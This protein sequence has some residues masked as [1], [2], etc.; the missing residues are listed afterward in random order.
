MEIKK[1]IQLLEKY[2]IKPGL[3]RI[4]AI[5]SYMGHP[6]KDYG[7][8]IVGGTNGKGSTCAMIESIL[9]AAGHKTGLYTSPHLMMMNERIRVNF[10]AIGDEDIES[11][12]GQLFNI[13]DQH[14]GLSDTTY[15]EFLTAVALKYFS[16]QRIDMAVLEVG[17]GGRFDATNATEPDIS[18]I[19]NIAMDHQRYLGTTLEEIA[20]EKAGIIRTGK[21]FVTT[22]KTIV[23]RDILETTS[24]N[25]G[26][27]LYA[28]D[29][30]FF[31][32]ENESGMEFRSI[33]RTVHNV[34]LSLTGTHQMSNAS[35]AIQTVIL[36]ER[37]GTG[38][39]DEEIK[40]GLINTVWQGR[41]EKIRE[42]PVVIM[43]VAHNPAGIKT[44]IETVKRFY[45][46]KS[47]TVL[48]GVSR[49]K[50][51]RQMLD[52]LSEV[53]DYYIFTAYHGE[54]SLAPVE[55]NNHVK[56]IESAIVISSYKAYDAAVRYTP[57]D[58]LVIVTGS[59]YLIGEIKHYLEDIKLTNSKDGTYEL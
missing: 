30:D 22:D 33:L 50:E 16:E 45:N 11:I 39:S 29:K 14:S 21:P 53:A 1:R 25:K 38:I 58:G 17:M 56:G 57:D 32:D 43:D 40:R 49:D 10:N 2:G 51:W 42:K 37:L 15:F 55:L 48:F 26:G 19:T 4:S 59:I 46:N 34:K 41:F 20:Y 23:S 3:E 7:I 47:I 6:E 52:M 9:R 13:I 27:L 5:L 18:V 24:K 44:L 12:S 8:I 36:L 35:A 28:I 54:R 31:Y